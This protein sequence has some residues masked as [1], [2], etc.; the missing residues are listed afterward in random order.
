MIR[1]SREENH[2]ANRR[3]YHMVR[4]AALDLGN[5]LLALYN[6]DAKTRSFRID[7]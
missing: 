7:L 6:K 2:A 3:T 5:P 4:A 1:L